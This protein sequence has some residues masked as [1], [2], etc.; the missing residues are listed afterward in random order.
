MANKFRPETIEVHK[1]RGDSI[2]TELRQYQNAADLPFTNQP[3]ADRRPKE[4]RS[5]MARV[6]T[7]TDPL[8]AE[9][10][11]KTRPAFMPLRRLLKR[12]TRAQHQCFVETPADELEA[13]R[14]T[15]RGLT[16]R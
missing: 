2:S 13:N 14:K 7:T 15:V 10:R 9:T 8:V 3:Q 6:T 11:S 1:A 5:A 16:A 4:K 12:V